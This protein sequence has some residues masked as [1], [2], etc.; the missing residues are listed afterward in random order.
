MTGS[1]TPTLADRPARLN[2]RVNANAVVLIPAD[3]PCAV[4]RDRAQAGWVVINDA[5]FS[6]ALQ[7]FAADECL[8]EVQPVY[9]DGSFRVYRTRADG[10]SPTR[11]E[12]DVDTP[13]GR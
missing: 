10:A 11:E 6:P 4:T 9:D 3:E 7:P 13:G 1:T 8:E 12:E 2:A 5:E